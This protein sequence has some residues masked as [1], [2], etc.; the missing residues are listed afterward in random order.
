VSTKATKLNQPA[1]FLN[2]FISRN[3]THP[4]YWNLQATLAGEKSETKHFFKWTN[5]I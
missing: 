4:Y 5:P 2:T 3:T 1:L